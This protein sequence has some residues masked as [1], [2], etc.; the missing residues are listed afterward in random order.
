[1][2]LYL[3]I[4]YKLETLIKNQFL[5]SLNYILYK[6]TADLIS[7]YLHLKR[8]ICQ[9]I[10]RNF[11][12]STMWRISP[13]FLAWKL[14]NFIKCFIFFGIVQL[15]TYLWSFNKSKFNQKSDRVNL[16]APASLIKC[17]LYLPNVRTIQCKLGT[18]TLTRLGNSNV[19]LLP[20]WGACQF[21]KEIT[22][23]NNQSLKR[24]TLISYSCLARQSF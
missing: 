5:L 14:F 12:W 1:M 15:S 20:V 16:V 9:H 23:K 7:S 11:C 10:Y 19:L 2:T 21:Y 24:K 22:I 4:K 18:E 8:G 13:L 6:G 3:Y 17:Q